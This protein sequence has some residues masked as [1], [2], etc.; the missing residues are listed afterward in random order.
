[1]LPQNPAWPLSR[2][3]PVAGL[4]VC[5]PDQ[6]VQPVRRRT[7][8]LSQIVLSPARSTV[9]GHRQLSANTCWK[10]KWINWYYY[11]SLQNREI[12]IVQS[13]MAQLVT[14]I[15]V[16]SALKVLEQDGLRS[17]TWGKTA[18]QYRSTL[19][20]KIQIWRQ[21]DAEPSGL[22][23]FWPKFMIGP[24]DWILCVVWV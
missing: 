5:L 18:K 19:P 20:K 13:I 10:D 21:K 9:L 6:A 17:T 15:R 16:A 7:T 8:P 23:Q 2:L 24:K 4:I 11:F 22:P 1:M 3:F 14:W 12:D